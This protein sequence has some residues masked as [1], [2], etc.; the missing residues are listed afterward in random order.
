LKSSDVA[1]T[2]D[3]DENTRIEFDA[4]GKLVA[5]SI[6]Q[7]RERAELPHFSFQRVATGAPA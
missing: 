4:K 5:M 1:E 7:A 3:L 2:R 6:E